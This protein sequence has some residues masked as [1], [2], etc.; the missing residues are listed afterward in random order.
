[1][2]QVAELVMSIKAAQRELERRDNELMR[3]LGITGGQA[4]AILVIGRLA[5]VSLKDLGELLIAES[6]H[7]SR[8]VDR[9]V[10]AGLVARRPAGADRR[11]LELTLTDAGSTLQQRIVEI[12]RDAMQVARQLVADRDL[13]PILGLLRELLAP[14]P[15]S[16]VIERRLALFVTADDDELG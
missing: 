7:P 1:V 6:G 5:P 4:D 3:P 16:D 9:L 2:D 14:L 8:L 12:R 10:D 11:R 15:V 13:A